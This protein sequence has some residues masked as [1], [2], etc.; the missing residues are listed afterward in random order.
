MCKL[1]EVNNKTRETY[2]N[3]W[4]R[5]DKN[6]FIWSIEHI[7]PQGENIPEEWVEMIADG[8]KVKAKEMQS[9]YVHTL[10]NLTLTGYNSK[11]SNMSF[12]KK[13]D[14]TSRDGAYVGYQNGLFLNKTLKDLN[15]WKVEN[16]TQRGA[17]LI[18]LILE[19]FDVEK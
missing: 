11:L 16:I 1:E 6:I 10:G 4:E 15:E 14:R 7:F 17:Y 2:V 19:Y 12:P 18:G 8:D 13:R 9:N 3:L 5:N